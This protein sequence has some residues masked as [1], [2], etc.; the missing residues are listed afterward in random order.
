MVIG[1]HANNILFI[2][3]V[4]MVNNKKVVTKSRVRKSLNS[5]FKEFLEEENIP[6]QI[7]KQIE[8][9]GLK[10]GRIIEFYQYLDTALVELSDHT[11]IEASI[12]HRCY[13]G[14]VDLYTPAGEQVISE[15]K[16][17]P[18]ILPRF[19]QDVLV[20]EVGDEYV[21][22]GYLNPRMVGAFSPA[23][24]NEYIIK[25][26]SDTSQGG[27]TV[28][29]SSVN[30]TS[31]DNIT[32]TQA[33]VGESKDIVYADSDNVYRKGEVYNKLQ[34]DLLLKEIWDYIHE[35]CPDEED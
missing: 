23:Q 1:P 32:F 16:H 28:S 18:C 8:N 35:H 9:H 2:R 4:F 7:T 5:K 21:L 29:P 33:D 24:P 13:G 11:L 19:Y 3:G 27:L 10:I 34:T 25:A 15:T 30:I 26:L 14:I 22:L 12:L 17:E 20:A 6:E 31:S